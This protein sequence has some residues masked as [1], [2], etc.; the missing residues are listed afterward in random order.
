MFTFIFRNMVLLLLSRPLS[1]HIL[2]LL[3]HLGTRIPGA[4]ALDGR[5]SL[6]CRSELPDWERQWQ[7]APVDREQSTW[8]VQ[9]ATAHR[10]VTGDDTEDGHALRVTLSITRVKTLT[11][12]VETLD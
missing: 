1:V 10:T 9:G 7:G 5:F 11:Q 3:L 12:L 2:P 8:C 6:A 4:F